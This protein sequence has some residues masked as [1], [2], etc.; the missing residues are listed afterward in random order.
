M[1]APPLAVAWR[2]KPITIDGGG[3]SPAARPLACG[4]AGNVVRRDADPA[5]AAAA[6]GGLA[7]GDQHGLLV[8]AGESPAA[9]EAAEAAALRL[10]VLLDDLAGGGEQ[11]L[12]GNFGEGV[13]AALAFKWGPGLREAQQP[14]AGAVVA[15]RIDQGLQ[16]VGVAAGA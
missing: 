8:C 5:I 9:L 1:A 6:V 4:G 2:H 3:K 15:F 10:N 13:G 14:R 12:V 11:P 7:V 16:D